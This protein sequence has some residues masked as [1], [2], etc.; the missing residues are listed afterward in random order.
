M[1]VRKKRTFVVAASIRPIPGYP[2][3]FIAENGD[4]YSSHQ[5]RARK[6]KP[7]H[8]RGGYPRIC[9]RKSGSAKKLLVSRLVALAYIGP[10]PS[11][12]HQACH[13]DD[14]PRNA[15]YK[16]LKWGTPLDNS[17]EM[18]QRGRSL[19]G[20]ARPDMIGDRH[21]LRKAPELAARGE[22]HGSA[23]LNCDKVRK[24]RAAVASGTPLTDLAR[25]YHVTVQAIW[26]I[27]ERQCW[28]HI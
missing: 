15:H 6:L 26:R 24:I 5:T 27:K 3:Y 9:L 4:I 16:N 19:K 12:I 11:K 8:G 2:G 10:P 28:R 25:Q 23:K 13:Q 22:G 14:N 7:W 21:H 17:R 20:R 18:V 1:T